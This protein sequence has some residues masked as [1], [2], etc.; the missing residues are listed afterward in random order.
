MY[1]LEK[2]L[3][4]DEPK[5]LAG[6]VREKIEEFREHMPII[7]RLGNTGMKARHWERVSEI[8]GLPIKADSEL[9]LS[10]ILSLHLEDYISQ[11]DPI[12]EAAAKE[13]ALERAIA[14]IDKEWI[15]MSFTVN[16]YKDTGTFVIA[17][18]DDIQLML[19]DHI[20]KVMTM[21]NSAYIK[22]FEDQISCVL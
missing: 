10:K 21:K 18:V 13:S 19:D 12:A 3:V 9:T 5:R 15:D 1:K 16:P 17:S 2:S 14:K 4:E 6:N 20:T 22:P 7:M 11:F 8:V